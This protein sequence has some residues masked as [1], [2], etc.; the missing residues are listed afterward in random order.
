MARAVARALEPRWARS[1]GEKAR[2]RVVADY[3]WAPSLRLLDELVMPA[4]AG[5]RPWRQAATD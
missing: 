3:A 5:V 2:A 1:M 4:P